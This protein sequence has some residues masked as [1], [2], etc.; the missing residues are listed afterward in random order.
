MVGVQPERFGTP[1]SP[2]PRNSAVVSPPRH[3][4]SS[5]DASKIPM[6]CKTMGTPAEP[7]GIAIAPRTMIS[8][9]KVAM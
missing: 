9:A 5:I 6:F 4:P 1:K 8:A 2:T 7:T 3:M